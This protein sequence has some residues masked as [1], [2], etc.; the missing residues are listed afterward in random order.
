MDLDTDVCVGARVLP[1]LFKGYSQYYGQQFLRMKKRYLYLKEIT[2]Q[3]V[4]T[5]LVR[6]RPPEHITL[7]PRRLRGVYQI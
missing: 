3:C 4:D 1:H 5:I 6:G 2:E 7:R